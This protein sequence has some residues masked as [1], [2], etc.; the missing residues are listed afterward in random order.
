MR[1]LGN[2]EVVTASPKANRQDKH[3]D[4]LEELVDSLRE[5]VRLLKS[6]LK[7]KPSTITQEQYDELCARYQLECS[8]NLPF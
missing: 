3:I 5:E 6:K 8:A 2:L 7:A 4:V 1:S